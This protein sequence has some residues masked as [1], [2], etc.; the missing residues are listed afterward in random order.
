MLGALAGDI[1]GSV[2]EH[3]DQWMAMRTPDFQPLFHPKSR[4]T[5]DTV[6]TIALA[7]ALLHGFDFAEI[8][9]QY[10]QRY[11]DAGYGKGFK[12]WVNS[13]GLEPYNSFGNGS[14][15]RVSPIAY[16]YDS[17][18]DVLQNAQRS[19][20]VTH[21]HVEG[22]KGAQA[23]A[24]AIYLART[25]KTK[26]EIRNYIVEEFQYQLDRSIDDM[27]PTYVFDAT[28]QGSVPQAIRAFIEADGFESAVR[29]A[30]SLGGDCDT[31]ACIAGSIAEAFYGG[32]PADIQNQTLQRLDKPLLELVRKF[33]ATYQIG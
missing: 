28:C 11:P 5:D 3:N 8:F 18:A 19:A 10:Y 29:L 1:I 17:L 27:R 23:T 22:I 2:Y 16:A 9:K 7:D 21:N 13:S 14:A 15:M 6:L 25:G 33:A 32:L 4:F 31:L 30:I 26:D 24:A 12:G 20:A